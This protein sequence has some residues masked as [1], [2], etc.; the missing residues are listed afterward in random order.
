M[1]IFDAP[2]ILNI[3]TFKQNYDVKIVLKRKD[4]KIWFYKGFVPGRQKA[5]LGPWRNIINERPNEYKTNST[6][7]LRNIIKWQRKSDF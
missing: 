7:V 6:K 4:K 5:D 1:T 3:Y 2:K